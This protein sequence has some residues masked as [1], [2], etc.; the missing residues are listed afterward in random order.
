[1]TL[2]QQFSS[3]SPHSSPLKLKA[4]STIPNSSPQFS[5]ILNL[6][7]VDLNSFKLKIGEN[8]GEL[9]GMVLKAFNF[10]GELYGELLE[11][12]HFLNDLDSFSSFPTFNQSHNQLNQSKHSD[13]QQDD[14][15]SNITCKSS[16]SK[17]E[18]NRQNK[19]WKSFSKHL[20]YERYH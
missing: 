19:K 20:R 2:L 16:F 11:K 5:L 14:V 9:L 4:F 12:C 3:S 6:K 7:E 1:M 8:C 17:T 13:K 18:I 10:Y 15:Y